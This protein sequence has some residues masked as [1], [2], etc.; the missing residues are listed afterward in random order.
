MRKMFDDELSFVDMKDY[1]K[2]KRKKQKSNK[3]CMVATTILVVLATL[4]VVLAVM[5]L[6]KHCPL[7][8]DAGN[9]EDFDEDGSG[10]YATE[11]DFE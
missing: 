8:N 1:V 11:N 2:N 6:K 3:V 7:C 9:L 5:K 4:G 10:V